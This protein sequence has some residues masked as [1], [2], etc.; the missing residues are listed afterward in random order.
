MKPKT[1]T[2]PLNALRAFAE[3]ARESSITR[4][5]LVMGTTQSSVS[6]HLAVLEEYMG[7]KL[8]ER[9][10][11]NIRL[12]KLGY[13]LAE[14]ISEPLET[15]AFSVNRMRRPNKSEARIA[16]RTSLPTLTNLF[17]IPHLPEFV[18]E[19]GA[20]F[21]FYTS[22]TPM[23]KGERFDV[24]LTRDL[25]LEI[26]SDEWVLAKEVI[27]CAGQPDR[28]EKLG[29]LAIRSTPLL[30]ATSRPDLVSRL[31]KHMGMTEDD[32][33]LGATFDHHYMSVPAAVAGLGLYIGPQLYMQSAFE[34]GD[35]Q[36][37]PESR[38]ETEM[39]YRALALDSSSNVGLSREF[40]KWLAR[41]CKAFG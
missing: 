11:R 34:R 37:V 23:E 8:V 36:I 12:T 32:V 21:D 2:I 6:R 39:R 9:S 4:A 16:V 31:V 20:L 25:Q 10:G 7:D 15:I 29:V 19:Y 35:L 38:F 33:S 30:T 22:L 18:Q 5:S 17:V 14:S 27:V 13:I 41:T 1:T 40:C 24:L 3:I 28:V 26:P